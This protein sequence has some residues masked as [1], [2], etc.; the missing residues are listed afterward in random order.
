MYRAIVTPV[1]GDVDSLAAE[2]RARGASLPYIEV[3]AIDG[4]VEVIVSDVGMASLIDHLGAHEV[5]VCAVGFSEDR[6]ESSPESD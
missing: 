5:A 3:A 2:L 1:D 4:T 6:T